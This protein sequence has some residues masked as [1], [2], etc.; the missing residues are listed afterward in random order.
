[1][2]PGGTGGGNVTTPS[3]QRLRQK[4]SLRWSEP[5][6]ITLRSLGIIA[7]RCTASWMKRTKERKKTTKERTLLKCQR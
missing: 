6:N 2:E 1:M 7:K 4:P 5:Y 3:W